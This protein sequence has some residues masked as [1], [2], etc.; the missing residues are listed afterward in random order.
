VPGKGRF[1]GTWCLLKVWGKCLISSM[2]SVLEQWLFY[3][4]ESLWS[5]E[6]VTPSV[7]SHALCSL[8]V[9][10]AVIRTM[11]WDERSCSLMISPHAIAC[12]DLHGSIYRKHTESSVCWSASLSFSSELGFLDTSS[13]MR[14]LEGKSIC[15][16]F[17]SVVSIAFPPGAVMEDLA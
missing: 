8:P 16:N 15:G 9:Y 11:A 5:R 7:Y 12:M 2:K 4:V 6:K 13:L 17:W 1:V 3:G 14:L 10:C